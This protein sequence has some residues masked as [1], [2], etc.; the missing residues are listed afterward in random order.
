MKRMALVLTL[1]ASVFSPVFAG[2]VLHIGGTAMV[3]IVAICAVVAV[4][5]MFKK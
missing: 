4:T 2:V 5:S 1:V 3:I